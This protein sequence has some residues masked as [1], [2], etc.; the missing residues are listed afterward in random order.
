M[1]LFEIAQEIESC[2][3]DGDNAVN[4]ET[5]EVID[6]AALDAL[7]MDF[8]DKAENIALWIKNL[9]AEADAVKNQKLIFAA[10][11]KAVENK[12]DSLK[13][14]LATCLQGKAFKTDRVKVSYRK[15]EVIAVQNIE[16]VPTEFLKYAAPTVDKAEVKKEIKAGKVV[17]GCVLESKQN[18]QIK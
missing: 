7:Q 18:I 16:K 4:T 3:I 1:K 17:P 10:R 2:V 11:Q 14:Y 8:N 5:G 15:S 9:D 6:R 13:E 12:R